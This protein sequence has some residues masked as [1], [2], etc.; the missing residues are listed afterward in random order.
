MVYGFN[1]KRRGFITSLLLLNS[2]LRGQRG[3]RTLT[4]Y[5]YPSGYL[6]LLSSGSNRS[7]LVREERIIFFHLTYIL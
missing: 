6:S 1:A 4:I 5:A 2:E 3:G 7:G